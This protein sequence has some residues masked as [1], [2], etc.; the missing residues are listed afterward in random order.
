MTAAR[1]AYG[2]DASG[3][4]HHRVALTPHEAY[5]GCS[6]GSQILSLGSMSL[7]RDSEVSPTH[8][9]DLERQKRNDTA[10]NKELLLPT[11][12]RRGKL[13][14]EVGVKI[15]PP[16]NTM[17]DGSVRDLSLQVILTLT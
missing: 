13:G 4:M 2:L 1:D 12:L 5:H 15:S 17:A 8:L 6:D 9:A 14:T 16:T 3:K 7:T 11:F 10:I